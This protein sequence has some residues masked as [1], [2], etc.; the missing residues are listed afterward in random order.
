MAKSAT[1][2]KTI[3]STLINCLKEKGV[4]VNRLYLYGSYANGKPRP[5][6]DIDIAVISSSFDKKNLVQRQE[7]L[8]EIIFPLGEPI[9]AIGYSLRE[10][11]QAHPFS[12]LREIITHGKIIYAK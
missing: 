4:K 11:K 2:L 1:E 6:S 5:D 12:F 9:E 8:G 3:F 10:F 7:I